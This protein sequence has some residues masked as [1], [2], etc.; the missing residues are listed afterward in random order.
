M[1]QDVITY[2]QPASDQLHPLVFKLAVGMVLCFV[3]AAWAFFDRQHDISELLAFA[4]L[5]LLIAV[6][7]PAVLWRVW[8]REQKGAVGEASR[9]HHWAARD[10]MVWGGQ[11]KGSHAAI[12]ALLPLAAVVCGMIGLGIVFAVVAATAP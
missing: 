5:L 11:L 10:F 4:S 8:R 7:L 2:R 12:D 3:V 1:G 6:A 9:F